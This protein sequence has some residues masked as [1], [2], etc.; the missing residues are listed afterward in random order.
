MSLR[1]EYAEVLKGAR[2]GLRLGMTVQIA[3][4]IETLTALGAEVRWAF[5]QHLSPDHAAAAVVVGLHRYPDE[6]RCPGVRVEGRRSKSTRPPMLTTGPR[7]AAG[8]TNRCIPR[9]PCWC[10]R[11]RQGEKWAARGAAR[12]VRTTSPSGRPS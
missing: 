10:A 9:T 5:V 7:Q 6:P 3:V 1:R 4:L 8:V 11:R 12:R 2:F